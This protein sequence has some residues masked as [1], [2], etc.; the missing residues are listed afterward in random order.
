MTVIKP[1]VT[2]EMIEQAARAS[3]A[4]GAENAAHEYGLDHPVTWDGHLSDRDRNQ[5]RLRARAA[6]EA[7]A[8]R[9]YAAALESMAEYI[10]PDD[11]L[12]MT[13]AEVKHRLRWQADQLRRA[14]R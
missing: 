6:L 10:G 3:F 12:L 14:G 13:P 7:A 5:E 1:T 4:A 2:D 8:P 9:L 11:G